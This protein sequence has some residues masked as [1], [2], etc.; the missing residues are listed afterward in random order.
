MAEREPRGFI[1][2]P[3]NRVVGTLPDATRA[4][5]TIEQLLNAGFER[6]AIELLSGK[7]GERRLDVTGERHGFAA[8]FQR[9]LL[10]ILGPAEEYRGLTHHLA[11]IRAGRFV[12]MVEAPEPDTRAAAAAILNGNGAEFVGFYGRWAW[13]GL[14]GWE[15]AGD[16]K[17]TSQEDETAAGGVAGVAGEY[18]QA[19]NRRDIDAL[20]AVFAD[21]AVFADGSGVLHQGRTAIR[22]A[23]ATEWQRVAGGSRLEVDA[24]RTKALSGGLAIVYARLSVEDPRG[25]DANRLVVCSFVVRRGDEGPRCVAMQDSAVW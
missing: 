11:D 19:W 12:I 15:T 22:E 18:A 2:Y 21:D 1:A 14:P 24:I 25:D 17:E 13:R 23:H 4:H 16:A 9:T 6:D 7:E 8:R 3:V 20:A 5:A 10:S